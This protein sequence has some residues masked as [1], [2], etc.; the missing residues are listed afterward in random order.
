MGNELTISEKIT[1]GFRFIGEGFKDLALAVQ[2][3]MLC[4][5]DYLRTMNMVLLQS[6]K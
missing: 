1:I 6:F 3:E 2:N 5:I 4:I